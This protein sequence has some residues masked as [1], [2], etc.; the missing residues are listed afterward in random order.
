MIPQLERHVAL[1]TVPAKRVLAAGHAHDH[2]LD[3]D[4]HADPAFEGGCRET[5]EGRTFGLEADVFVVEALLF[6]EGVEYVVG[7]G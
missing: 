3:E 6:A 5:S 1:E 2:V 4:L 7:R